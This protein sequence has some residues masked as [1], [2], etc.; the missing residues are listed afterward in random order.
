MTVKKTDGTLIEKTTY[1]TCTVFP[2]MFSSHKNNSLP[3]F[4]VKDEGLLVIPYFWDIY[5][6]KCR[7]FAK[8]K[9][10]GSRSVYISE[11]AHIA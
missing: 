10:F 1:S 8:H 4:T 2:M 9:L 11:D 3:A 6:M 7:I 5:E